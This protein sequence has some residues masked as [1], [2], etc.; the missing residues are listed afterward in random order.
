MNAPADLRFVPHYWVRPYINSQSIG[1]LYGK[2]VPVGVAQ[3]NLGSKAGTYGTW[4][5][6]VTDKGGRHEMAMPED[7]DVTAVIVAMRLSV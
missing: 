7:G 6:W 3:V 4:V 2:E 1:M 5:Y